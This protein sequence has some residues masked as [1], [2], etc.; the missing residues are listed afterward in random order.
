MVKIWVKTEIIK[1]Y[2][3]KKEQPTFGGLVSACLRTC[4]GKH[5]S[6]GQL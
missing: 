4:Y 2:G 1:I 3:H 6:T 5:E